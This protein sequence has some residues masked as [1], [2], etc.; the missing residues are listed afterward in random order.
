M[1][2]LVRLI[3]PPGTR[4]DDDVGLCKF[5]GKIFENICGNFRNIWA[6]ILLNG[7]KG[8]GRKDKSKLKN[9]GP[10]QR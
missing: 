6:F 5:S 4:S 10:F 1:S 9:V 2:R 8:N 3:S 7:I